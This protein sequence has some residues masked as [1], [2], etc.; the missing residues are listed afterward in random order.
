MSDTH[1][2]PTMTT[3]LTTGWYQY[4]AESLLNGRPL[5]KGDPVNPHHILVANAPRSYRE[6]IAG[7]VRNFRPGLTV[8]EVDPDEITP[9]ILDFDPG[10]IVLSQEPPVTEGNRPIWIVLY[11]DEKPHRVAETEYRTFRIANLELDALLSLIDRGVALIRLDDV[12]LP[13]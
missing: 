13:L 9:A 3:S 7:A 4:A 5:P 1:Y 11:G 12:D 6:A 2:L 10:V 8:R